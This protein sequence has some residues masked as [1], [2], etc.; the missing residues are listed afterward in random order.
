MESPMNIPQRAPRTRSC[1]AEE[2]AMV[3]VA[4]L[5]A[6]GGSDSVLIR[7]GPGGNCI[8]LGLPVKSIV[9]YYFQENRRLPEDLFYH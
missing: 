4:L 3:V 7:V 5:A 1:T 8:K 9:R 2:V 6:R